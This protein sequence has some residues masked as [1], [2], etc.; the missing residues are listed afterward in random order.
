MEAVGVVSLSSSGKTV[1][2]WIDPVLYMAP[3]ARVMDVL[4]GQ[5]GEGGGVR[6]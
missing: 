6:E 1:N 4:E 3:L 5:G 2:V